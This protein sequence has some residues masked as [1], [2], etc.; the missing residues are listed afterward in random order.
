M[1]NQPSFNRKKRCWNHLLFGSVYTGGIANADGCG[2]RPVLERA[3]VGVW[4]GRQA[5]RGSGHN[6]S[7]WGDERAVKGGGC[8]T[9]E[10]VPASLRASIP[11]VRLPRGSPRGLVLGGFRKSPLK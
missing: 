3:G 6:A 11:A 9:W 1:R 5:G 7:G 10:A 2:A 8:E 4:R